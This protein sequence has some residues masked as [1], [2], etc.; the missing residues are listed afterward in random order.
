MCF[1]CEILCLISLAVK[2]IFGVPTVPRATASY[3]FSTIDSLISGMDEKRAGE[4]LILVS[5]APPPGLFLSDEHSISATS[6]AF[7]GSDY[8]EL[9]DTLL[10]ELET[11]FGAHIRS[12][13]LE[14][15]VVPLEYYPSLLPYPLEL[16]AQLE[17]AERESRS[18]AE[19]QKT[20]EAQQQLVPPLS[21]NREFAHEFRY[22][23]VATSPPLNESAASAARV[24]LRR[25]RS[26]HAHR[27]PGNI[28]SR[29]DTLQR[30]VWRCV[31]YT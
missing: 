1:Q 13:L 24:R 9:A 12:G 23:S 28:W 7:N 14:L 29:G 30:T 8:A 17:R 26:G 19:T 20:L 6:S 27:G 4:S 16:N 18:F 3:L 11:R 10:E 25:P 21:L 5:I 2:Y 22:L 15:L 31:L